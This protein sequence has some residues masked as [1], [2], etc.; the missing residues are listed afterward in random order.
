MSNAS[1]LVQ[2]IIITAPN[3]QKNAQGPSKE[4]EMLMVIAIMRAAALMTH[5]IMFASKDSAEQHAPQMQTVTTVT[6]TQQTFAWT[7]ALAN[8]QLSLIVGME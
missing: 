3:Q 8:T 7:T 4:P 1:C 5:S 2:L 6:Q